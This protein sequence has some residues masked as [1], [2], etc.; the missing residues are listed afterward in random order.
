[1]VDLVEN[2]AQRVILYELTVIR[3][4][5][6]QLLGIL[7]RQVAVVARAVGGLCDLRR[8]E[9]LRAALIEVQTLENDADEVLRGALGRLFREDLDPRTLMKWKEV[10]EHLEEATDRCEDVA[11]LFENV[12]LEYA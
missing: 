7:E 11:D 5:A 12:L 8:P 4:E 9:G 1:M 3:E 2:V 10:I 6:W